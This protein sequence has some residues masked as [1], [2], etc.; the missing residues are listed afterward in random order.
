M[1][2]ETGYDIYEEGVKN[3]Y[4]CK[5]EDGSDFVAAVW[6]GWTH[7]PDVLNPDAREWFGGKYEILTQMG[8][9]GF[10]NDM[11]EPALFYGEDYL[12]KAFEKLDE[13]RKQELNLHT[14]FGMKNLVLGLSNR[15]ED[16]E[17]FYH[18]YKGERTP[19]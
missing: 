7:F 18:E 12:T 4:F 3:G 14:F 11:N 10:W 19:P 16:Y 17:S 1:K 2:I 8:I 6:P 15:K 5:R 9:D 13:Y